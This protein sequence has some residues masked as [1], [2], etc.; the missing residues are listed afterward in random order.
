M[1]LT[2]WGWSQEQTLLLKS[3]DTVPHN[4]HLNAFTNESFNVVLP[5]ERADDEAPGPRKTGHE[6]RP[7]DFHTWMDS[8]IFAFDHPFFFVTGDDGTFEI[9][10]VPAGLQK[11]VVWQP[12]IGY[13]TAGFGSGMAVT[14]EAGKTTDVGALKIDPAKVKL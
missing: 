9:K 8:W 7:K 10:G 12:A 13:V 4:V 6:I 14:S 11:L 2:S 1:S 3:S 5:A